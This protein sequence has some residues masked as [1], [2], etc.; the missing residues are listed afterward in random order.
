MLATVDL[1]CDSLG[2]F[3]IENVK[4][5]EEKKKVIKRVFSSVEGSLSFRHRLERYQFLTAKTSIFLCVISTRT[6]AVLDITTSEPTCFSIA[7]K[8]P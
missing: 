6:W 3:F 4:S 2:L 7:S 5:L 1:I 8:S